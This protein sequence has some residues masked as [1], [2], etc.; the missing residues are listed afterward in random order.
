MSLFDE[1]IGGVNNILLL[2]QHLVDLQQLFQILLILKK[3]KRHNSFNSILTVHRF[4]ESGA[5]LTCDL[6]DFRIALLEWVAAVAMISKDS[7]RENTGL[8]TRTS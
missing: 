8:E 2:S 3:K 4:A 6:T 5:S 7:G 1:L